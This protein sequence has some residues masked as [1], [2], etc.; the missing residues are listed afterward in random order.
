MNWVLLVVQSAKTQCEDLASLMD[1]L[2]GCHID[3][4]GVVVNQ[5]KT[6]KSNYYLNAQ[7]E[8]FPHS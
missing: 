3:R 4:I 2:N 5:Y 7:E 1:Q 6:N 8:L